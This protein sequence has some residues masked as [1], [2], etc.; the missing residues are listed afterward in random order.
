MDENEIT[1]W[2]EDDSPESLAGEDAP[3]TWSEFE[4]AWVTG[5]G[6]DDVEVENA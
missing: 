3:D 5:E 6:D 4:I 1:R 2:E